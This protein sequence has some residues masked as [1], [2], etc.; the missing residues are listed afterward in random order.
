MFLAVFTI[1]ALCVGASS[2][3]ADS[4]PTKRWDMTGSRRSISLSAG[5]FNGN[6]GGPTAIAGNYELSGTLGELAG[7]ELSIICQM[8][9]PGSGRFDLT[10]K[11]GKKGVGRAKGSFTDRIRWEDYAVDLSKYGPDDTITCTVTITSESQAGERTGASI[12]IILEGDADPPERAA[13][14][15]QA[16]AAVARHLRTTIPPG[17]QSYADGDT[18]TGSV[19]GSARKDNTK[20]NGTFVVSTLL[21]ELSASAPT[22]ESYPQILCDGSVHEADRKEVKGLAK[23]TVKVDGTRVFGGKANLERRFASAT[24]SE[25]QVVAGPLDLSGYAPGA[26][27]EC[28]VKLR[29]GSR[30]GE[31]SYVSMSAT[32]Q[33]NVER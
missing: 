12:N 6:G 23:V 24:Y 32:V 18:H 1:L 8:G 13:A 33:G 11:V 15:R 28:I 20:I 3:L 30:V 7:R 19:G 4:V 2:I 26:L 10:V 22:S 16:G 29:R 17:W 27:V 14:G 5:G 31:D 21:G 9:I 25:F